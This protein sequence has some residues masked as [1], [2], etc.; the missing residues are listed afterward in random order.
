MTYTVKRGDTLYGISNQLGVSVVDLVNL[1]NI[2]NN[3]IYVGQVLKVPTTSGSNPN[4]TFI[5]T[6]TKGDSLY[7]IARR[8]ETTVNDIIKLNNLKSI[9]LS[10]GDK[11]VIPETGEEVSSLPNFINYTVQRGDTLYNISKKYNVSVNTIMQDNNMKNNT[12][13]VGQV[14]KIRTG[15]GSILECFGEEYTPSNT[16]VYIVKKGDSL[17]SIAKSF[18]TSVTNIINKNNMTSNNL[19]IGQ[20]LII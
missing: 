4:S 2:K 11:L 7:S 8:Y 5:Y 17:Y 15:E 19:Q 16:T 9:N 3:V 13:S 20:K 14:L 10:I 12:L 1:N 18:N 6:V